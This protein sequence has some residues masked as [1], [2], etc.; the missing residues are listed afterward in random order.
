VSRREPLDCWQTQNSRVN[1]LIGSCATKYQVGYKSTEFFYAGVNENHDTYTAE[2][3]NG[4]LSV[5]GK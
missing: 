5:A 2:P 4:T 1:Q 3:E